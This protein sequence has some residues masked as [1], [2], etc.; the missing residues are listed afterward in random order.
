MVHG[1]VC[2]KFLLW[3][4]VYDQG[5]EREGSQMGVLFVCSSQIIKSLECLATKS[6]LSQVI[7]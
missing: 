7:S 4:A 3:C 1:R 2:R 5:L 6:K